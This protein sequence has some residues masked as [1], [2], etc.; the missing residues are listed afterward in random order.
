MLRKYLKC[1]EIDVK[2]TVLRRLKVVREEL[3]NMWI[4][5]TVKSWTDILKYE[6]LLFGE[7]RWRDRSSQTIAGMADGVEEHVVR[8]VIPCS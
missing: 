2:C 8:A 6:H 7:V 1:R 4:E 5:D 3:D